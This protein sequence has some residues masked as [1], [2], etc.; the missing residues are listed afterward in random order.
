M[1]FGALAAIGSFIPVVKYYALVLAPVA[2]LISIFGLVATRKGKKRGRAMA[3]AGLL[4]SIVSIAVVIVSQIYLNNALN[5][6]KSDMEQAFQPVT[7]LVAKVTGATGASAGN[8][9]SASSAAAQAESAASAS[10]TQADSSSSPAATSDASAA[11]TASTASASSAA[12]SA[13]AQASASDAS[14]SGTSAGADTASSGAS[15]SESAAASSAQAAQATSTQNAA[16][17]DY[18]SLNLG[19]TATLDNGLAITVNS[20]QPDVESFDGST[21][22]GVSITYENRGAASVPY[23]IYDWQAQDAKDEP[24]NPT[25][26]STQED[27]LNSGTLAPGGSVTG[28]VFFDGDIVKVRYIATAVQ[29]DADIAWALK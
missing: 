13:A 4:L 6:F 9:S 27:L 10:A 22:T 26:V 29:A 7:S 11:S 20:V 1:V 25:Y 12:A 19:E 5:S 24:R 2:L 15:A 14:A 16:S 8:T 18:S 3:V 21:V 17:A 23:N 28:N